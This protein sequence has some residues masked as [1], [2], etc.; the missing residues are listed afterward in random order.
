L[1]EIGVEIS[2]EEFHAKLAKLAKAAKA[3]KTAK[4]EPVNAP[5]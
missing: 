1:R 4:L 5:T 2:D 3:A